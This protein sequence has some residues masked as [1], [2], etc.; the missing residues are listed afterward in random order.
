MQL[1]IAR[2]LAPPNQPAVLPKPEKL[3]FGVSALHPPG[4][5]SSAPST[6][7]CHWS[8]RPMDWMSS[9][10]Q[11][12]RWNSN[13][14]SAIANPSDNSTIRS[15]SI[16]AQRSKS[17][18]SLSP[19]ATA[20]TLERSIAHTSQAVLRARRTMSGDARECMYRFREPLKKETRREQHPRKFQTGMKA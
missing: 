7:P 11:V 13:P 20:D 12:P 6:P 15:S 8:H 5:K 1:A 10:S 9:R 4:V 14:S 3:Q 16:L 19:R 17:L 2:P 18:F